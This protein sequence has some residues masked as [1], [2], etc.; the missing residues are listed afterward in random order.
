MQ[1]QIINT[2]QV[3]LLEAQTSAAKLGLQGGK[4]SN[5]VID[6]ELLRAKAEDFEAV[7]L[8]QMIK[9]MFDTL[10]TDGPFGGGSS[11][12]IYRGLMV[13]EFGKSISRNGG[14]GIADSVYRALIEM[15]ER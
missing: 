9:P 7:F 13:E 12:E 1:T 5:G 15:Q 8:T 3:Q 10:P 2:A 6:K 11:E 4:S 14:I